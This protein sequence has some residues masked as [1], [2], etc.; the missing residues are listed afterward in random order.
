VLPNFRITTEMGAKIYYSG[1]GAYGRQMLDDHE[2]AAKWA[3][4]QGFADAKKICVSGA[5]YGGYA[6]L[7]TLAR[8]TNPFACGISGLPVAD[9]K[10]QNENADYSRNQGSVDFWKALVGVKSWDDPIVKELSPVHNADKIKVPVYMY[11]GDEDTR[12]PPRQAE[13][14]AEALTKAGNAPKDYYIG[15]GEGHGYGRTEANIEN[16]ERMLKFLADVFNR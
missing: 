10:Y 2:D 4:D 1:F 14:M 7:Q 6:A 8:P 3:I 12:T 16:Y 5:S 11:I 15:K 9:L 13:R